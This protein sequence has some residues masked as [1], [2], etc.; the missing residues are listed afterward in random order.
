MTN[1]ELLGEDHYKMMAQGYE[2]IRVRRKSFK[3]RPDAYDRIILDMDKAFES[4][5]RKFLD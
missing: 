1:R 4:F 5:Y 2:E 3:G